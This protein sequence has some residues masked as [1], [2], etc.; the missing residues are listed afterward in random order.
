MELLQRIGRS[1]V[2]NC[3]LAAAI[4]MV[5][6]GFARR[7]V[8]AEALE[9]FG[10]SCLFS[11]AI[12]GLAFA[13]MPRQWVVTQRFPVVWR[14]L[15]RVAGMAAITAVGTLVAGGII[16]LIHPG[17]DP[18]EEFWRTYRFS[19]VIA[20]TF[21]V[22]LAGYHAMRYKLDA[23]TLELRT[24]E[25][26]RER[27]L[28]QAAASQLESLESRVHPHFLFNALNSISSLIQEDPA[29]AER[30]LGQMAALLRFSLDANRAGLVPLE[31][32][33]KIVRDYLEIEKARFGDRLRFA[34]EVDED[35]GPAQVPPLA[36]QTLVENAVKYAVSPRRE[37]A[38]IRVTASRDGGRLA[39]TVA[40]SGSGFDASALQPGH[41][42]DLLHQRLMTQF[43]MDAALRLDRGTEEMRVSLLIPQLV[44][45]P[46]VASISG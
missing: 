17:Y 4:T 23:A 25:L 31:R 14:W 9:F 18:L 12:G 34:L 20:V 46:H 28:K 44:R 36:V 6:Y 24:R 21:G 22:A 16:A 38:S 32:E 41:G 15:A 2:I 13:T 30:L 19:V 42:L 3:L 10:Y 5:M 33:M 1:V 45:P 43:G 29:R 11:N 7:F 27:A 8:W 37:G 35:L 26:E 39:V 40:D